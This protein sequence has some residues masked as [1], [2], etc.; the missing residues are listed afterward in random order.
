MVNGLREIFYEVLQSE[1][2]HICGK[3]DTDLVTTQGTITNCPD[4]LKIEG[5]I[6]FIK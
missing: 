1:K 6:F 5:T 4:K 2:Q 3:P